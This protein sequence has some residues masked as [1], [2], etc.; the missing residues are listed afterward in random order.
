MVNAVLLAYSAALVF[1]PAR[2]VHARLRLLRPTAVRRPSLPLRAPR[3]GRLVLLGIG[4]AAGWASAAVAGAMA[5]ALLAL[6]AW[7]RL[8]ARR[9]RLHGLAEIR[10]WAEALG[11]MS[12]E[13]RVGATPADAA[14]S[15][16]RD[17]AP[18]VTEV[19]VGIASTARLGGDVPARLRG[20]AA[21]HPEC[22]AAL[23][24]LGRSWI[25]AERHGVP[26]ADVLDA[27]RRDLEF[28]VA[29]ADGLAAR[30]AGPRATG[31]VLAALPLLGVVLGEAM[32]ADPFR[33]LF[34]HEL[35]RLLLVVGVGLDC[36]GVWWMGRITAQGGWAS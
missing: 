17:A 27:M 20:A 8:A 19:L 22:A 11:L 5:G 14:E 6:T 12:A 24:R 4:V 21:G 35:G 33:V 7:S 13:L 29:T 28:R 2:S 31:A 1:W 10:S 3:C 16:A 15:V 23:A 25:A 9:R 26:L 30:L 32:G 36:L 18:V 34:D